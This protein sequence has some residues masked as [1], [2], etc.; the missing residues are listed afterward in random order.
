M[1]TLTDITSKAINKNMRAGGSPMLTPKGKSSHNDH[2]TKANFMTPTMASAKKANHSQASTPT[3]TSIEKAVTGKWMTSAVRRV[4]LRRVEG[5]GTPR[6]KKEGS[7]KA[8]NALTFP[9]KVRHLYN[10]NLENCFM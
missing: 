7:K 3:S 6:S 8:N 1:G 4:G 5:D 9:D 10:I 2:G